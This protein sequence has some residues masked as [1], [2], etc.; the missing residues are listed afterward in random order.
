MPPP[1]NENANTK[2]PDDEYKSAYSMIESSFIPDFDK[3]EEI[4][5]HSEVVYDPILLQKRCDEIIKESELY[6]LNA[7]YF[8]LDCFARDIERTEYEKK[9][10]ED[11][12][13]FLFNKY[14]NGLYEE[15]LE[16]YGYRPASE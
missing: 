13:M 14:P 1:V 16:E 11:Y 6:K 9:A 7:I 4:F 3:D 15:L 12:L 2:N 8:Y 5:Q 10:A